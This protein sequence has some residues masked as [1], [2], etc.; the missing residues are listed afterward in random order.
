MEKLL[1]NLAPGE[2]L[3]LVN[4][5]PCFDDP[6]ELYVLL[7][8][9]FHLCIYNSIN[10]SRSRQ[11]GLSFVEAKCSTTSEVSCRGGKYGCKSFIL[12]TG[13]W[14][15]NGGILNSKVFSPTTLVMA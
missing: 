12:K 6:I 15:R 8:G 5:L 2:P 1:L 9:A 10:V 4:K 11:S 7:A 14:I 13:C 3:A